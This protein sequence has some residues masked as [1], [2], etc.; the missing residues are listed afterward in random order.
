MTESTPEPIRDAA[1]RRASSRQQLYSIPITTIDGREQTLERYRGDVM[2][3]V[4]V[5]SKCGFTP[6]YAGLEAMYRRYKHRGFVVLGFPCDQFGNQEPGTADEI[7]QFCTLAYDVTFPLF[8]KVD[9]NGPNEH[10]IYAALKSYAPGVLGTT[11]IKW[12]FTKF[13]VTRDGAAVTRYS[14]RDTPEDI[15]ADAAFTTALG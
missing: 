9:V 2:L 14:S 10:P 6:Q 3:V 1:A 4:N 7:R 11:A 15:E 5:A 12:N 13:L 8:A